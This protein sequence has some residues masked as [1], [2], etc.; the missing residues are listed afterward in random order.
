[1]SKLPVRNVLFFVLSLTGASLALAEVQ[2]GVTLR[3][4]KDAAPGSVSLA[5]TGGEPLFQVFR[6]TDKTNVVAPENKLGETQGRVWGDAPPAGVVQFYKITSPCVVSPPEVCD[7]IDNDCDGTV[8]GPGSETSCALPNADAVCLAGACAIGSCHQ[9]YGDCNT[10]PV[11]GCETNLTGSPNC[12]ACGNNCDDGNACN[13]A[14][15]CVVVAA[16]TCQPGAN[17]PACTA[18][19]AGFCNG[20]GQ[21]AASTCGDGCIDPANGEQCDDGNHYNLDGSDTTCKYEAVTRMT[22]LV[23]QATPAPAFCTPTTNRLGTQSFTSTFVGQVNPQLQ[24]DIDSGFTNILTQMYGLDDLT[25]VAD[26]SGLS[27]GFL[28][29]TLDPAKGPWPG[30]SPIDW[31]FLADPTSVTAG[32]AN[33]IL[34]HG[35]LAARAL[36][37]GPGDVNLSQVLGGVLRM[38]SARIAAILNGSPAPNVPPPPPAQLAPGL[39]VFQTVTASGTGQGL[40]G[41]ITVESLSRVPI[42]PTLAQGGTTACGACAGSKQYTACGG[43][44]VGPNCNSLLDAL[45][46][47]CK[48]VSCLITA[49]NATQPDVAGTDGDIDTLTLGA[50]NKVPLTL[51]TGNDDAY[52]SYMK[53][54]ANRAHIT[55]EACTATSDCQAGKTCTGGV[56]Q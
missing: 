18:C 15:T 25:G 42:P 10:S 54:N 33:D 46:G 47:G 7:G 20:S 32:V 28:S 48:I 41:N 2:D 35:A 50:L 17:A 21:C 36:T 31:W 45:V 27:I 56:C 37:A 5:W 44:P 34:G 13:G 38:R 24:T 39:T 29:G 30:S 16:P 9:Y 52:S 12:G 43:Q 4:A 26:P 3:V 1:M 49:I 40:C 11:D 22:S 51:T 6:S 8:D 23:I 19:A 53:W 14:E 55:G